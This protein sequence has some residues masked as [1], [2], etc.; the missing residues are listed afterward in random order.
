[1]TFIEF[2]MAHG[3]VIDRPPRIGHWERY[4]TQTHP[5][6]RNGAVKWM[7]DHG[8][9]QDHAAHAEVIFWREDRPQ[10]IDV[11]VMRQAINEAE[12]E[13]QKLQEK[14]AMLASTIVNKCVTGRHP[15]L[16]KKGFPKEKGLIWC[17][18]KT[19]HLV[20]PMHDERN[21]LVGL[22]TINNDGEKKFLYGQKTRGSNF[23]L[24][25]GGMS[26]LC[27]G[28]VT[29]L[30]VR[31]AMRHLKHNWQ[32]HVCFSAHNLVAVAKR[33]RPGLVVADNDK[34]GA[35]EKVA[36]QTGWRWWMSDTQGED[37]NDYHL[38]LGIFQA[39]KGLFD[40]LYPERRKVHTVQCFNAAITARKLI[41][42]GHADIKR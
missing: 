39:S 4:P 16:V 10:K 7:G 22:Q 1:M 26:V 3:I 31:E 32:I 27:E 19:E 42:Q 30:S 20:I 35:G 41:D 21:N 2:C 28:Y 34:S 6:K 29:G 13:R 9:L 5:N 8:F 18:D 36:R 33:L 38:R 11:R 17:H 15:Y 12:K 25:R 40:L 24:G 14:A 37:F 23:I